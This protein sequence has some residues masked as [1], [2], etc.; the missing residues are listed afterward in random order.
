MASSFCFQAGIQTVPTE[1]ARVLLESLQAIG[2]DVPR[3][4]AA[5]GLSG[6]APPSAWPQGMAI[7]RN[8][9]ARL[10]REAI[11]AMD[12]HLCRREGLRSLPYSSFK[13]ICLAMMSC[14]TLGTA[15]EVACDSY[16]EIVEGG[17]ALS[18]TVADGEARLALNLGGHGSSVSDL[19][20]TM[21]ALAS[22]HRLLGWLTHG[23]ITLTRVTMNYP[24]RLEQPAFNMLLQL[25]PE[26]GQPINSI[27][28]SASSLDRPVERHYYELVELLSF[29][30]FDL[31]PPAYDDSSMMERVQSATIA[32]M[33]MGERLP[34]AEQ[35]AHMFGL[36]I[37]TFRRRIVAENSSITAIRNQ[38]RQRLAIQMLR[39]T[40]LSVKEV[41]TRV[42]F[43]DAASF[44][45]AFRAWVGCSPDKF[46]K[47]IE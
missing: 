45:R 17:G 36:S 46:R 43:L 9:F 35:L 13:L 16:G 44:R 22:Y 34:D 40:K 2:G 29:F 21:Y 31:F 4:L 41:A 27:G 42:Q 39:K 12:S 7:S 33:L 11:V 38:C 20:V 24:A 32:A 8:S 18:L 47:T 26:F 25:D 19:L 3:A 28:F 37:S 14:P 30:P 1:A 15:I 23:E 10:A 5:A 6:A